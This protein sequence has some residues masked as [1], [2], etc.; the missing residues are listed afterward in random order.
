MT[1]RIR[2][3]LNA[4]NLVEAKEQAGEMASGTLKAD[5]QTDLEYQPLTHSFEAV[6]TVGDGR[7]DAVVTGLRDGGYI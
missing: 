4:T 3:R 2:I 1:D 5:E 6:F 7:L